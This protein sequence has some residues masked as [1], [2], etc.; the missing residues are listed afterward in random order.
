MRVNIITHHS[1]GAG[2][3]KD[4]NLLQGLLAERN[5][6]VLKIGYRDPQITGRGSL[7]IGMRADINFF[8]EVVNIPALQLAKTNIL[9]PNSEW[10][11]DFSWGSLLPQFRL[12]L[13]KTQDCYKIWCS[14]VG[15]SRCRYIGWEALDRFDPSV[16]REMKFL[17][18][19]GKSQTK[20]TA[21][22]MEA[23]Q[24]YKIPYKITVSA[25]KPEIVKS[26]LWEKT[27]LPKDH[28]DRIV[29]V[30]ERF[31]DDEMNTQMNKHL[32]HIMPSKYEGYGMAINEAL[33]CAS[34]VLTTNAAPMRDF[35][36]IPSRFLIDVS[37]VKRCNAAQFNLVDPASIARRVFEARETPLSEI[38]RLSRLARKGFLQSRN[39]FRA[40][41]PRVFQEIG[42]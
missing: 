39:D 21:A 12:V 2:L 25:F 4:A 41:I 10:W 38:Q 5:H 35:E 24:K 8:L 42:L 22:V 14:K 40:R 9:V 36:G 33:G 7:P 3:E 13:C 28:P 30:V 15:A 11:S 31:S 29:R 1:N 34:L 20:N 18:C 6:Q 23:W 32:F 19:A 17:H 16:P 27:T 37:D 26:C